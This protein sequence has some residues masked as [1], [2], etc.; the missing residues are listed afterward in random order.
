MNHGAV[1]FVPST[2]LTGTAAGAVFDFPEKW[3]G[4]AIFTNFGKAIARLGLGPKSAIR[5]GNI[6]AG[7]LHDS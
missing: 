6:P 4:T 1:F 7:R 5:T 2:G 3:L